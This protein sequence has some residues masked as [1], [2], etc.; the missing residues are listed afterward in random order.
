M[1][2]ARLLQYP[3]IARMVLNVDEVIQKEEQ[4]I[5]EYLW[6]MYDYY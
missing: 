5:L 1:R 6:D 3:N 4:M 2:R